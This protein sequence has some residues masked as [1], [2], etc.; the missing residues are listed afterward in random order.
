MQSADIFIGLFLTLG[1]GFGL[2]AVWA[3]GQVRLERRTARAAALPSVAE[4]DR[5]IADL[6][7]LRR[8]LVD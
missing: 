6:R 2:L 1:V 5:R 8:Q 4:I 3:R 7:A